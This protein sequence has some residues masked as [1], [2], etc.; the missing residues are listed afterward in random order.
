MKSMSSGIMTNYWEFLTCRAGQD[1]RDT[2]RNVMR[3]S[4]SGMAEA[5][6]QPSKTELG[7]S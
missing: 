5:R 6:Y 3:G 7:I 1:L 2:C 4:I